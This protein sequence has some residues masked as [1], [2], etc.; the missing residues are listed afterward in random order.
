MSERSLSAD[1]LVVG[2]GII[3]LSIARELATRGRRVLLIDRQRLGREA[4]W[5]GAGI[6]PPGSWYSD[7]PWADELARLS[8]A[9]YE[10]WAQELGDATGIDVEFSRCGAL[11]FV[12][13][14][15]AG[16]VAQRFA[17]WQQL[18]IEVEP[19]SPAD[20]A[21]CEPELQSARFADHSVWHVPSEAQVR[22]PRL[23]AAVTR[24][25]Q[26]AGV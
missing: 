8:Y 9:A 24:A 5:A 14:A 4:S 21:R 6:L 11:Y 18:G 12:E 10:R 15:A 19:L 16:T 7:Q 3:G 22:N 20:I 17:R 13:P 23:L 25:A 2:G 1:C 26:L